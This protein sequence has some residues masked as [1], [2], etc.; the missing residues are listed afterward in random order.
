MGLRQANTA[1]LT[2]TN[3]KLLQHNQPQSSMHVTWRN[4]SEKQEFG[5]KAQG[6]GD[7]ETRRLLWCALQFVLHL[8]PHT[9]DSSQDAPGAV[10]GE[11]GALGSG[12]GWAALRVVTGSCRPC[13]VVTFPCLFWGCRTQPCAVLGEVRHPSP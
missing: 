4:S 11:A 1:T 5:T 13:L 6:N 10:P 8:L 7:K 3:R 9:V 2:P 12:T